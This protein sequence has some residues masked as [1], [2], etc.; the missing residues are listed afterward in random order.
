MS[1]IQ[2]QLNAALLA[3]A[4]YLNIN[5]GPTQ[6]LSQQAL[7]DALTSANAS[8][9]LTTTEIQMISSQYDLVATQMA[10]VTGFQAMVFQKHGASGQPGDYVISFRGTEFQFSL[11][12]AADL[13]SDLA[14]V[15]AGQAG[16]QDAALHTFVSNLTKPI[17]QGGYGFAFGPGS[18]DATGHSLGG[19]LVQALMSWQ[20]SLIHQGYTFNGAGMGGSPLNS[21]AEAVHA[22]R[23]AWLQTKGFS[24]NILNV[25]GDAG[26]EVVPSL[27]GPKAGPVETMFIESQVLPTDNHSLALQVDSL[28]VYRAFEALTGTSQFKVDTVTDILRA[29]TASPLASLET[30]VDWFAAMFPS[31]GASSAVP[32]GDRNALHLAASNLTSYLTG[33][34][35]GSYTL[36][37]LQGISSTLAS[38]AAQNDAQGLALRYA[39][40]NAIP[41]IVGGVDYAA[42]FNQGHR[43]D[44]ANFSSDY[45]S[46]R[47]Q[48]LQALF[49][50]NTKDLT[51]STTIE[52]GLVYRD[53]ASA[54]TLGNV[55]LPDVNSSRQ[56]VFG[57]DLIGDTI[58][59]G[60]QAD[61]LYGEGGN[62]TL[63]GA[64]GND[65]L[66]GGAGNDIL[67]GGGGVTAAAGGVGN[68]TYKYYT[69]DGLLNISDT[70]G[71]NNISVNL[72][73]SS[74]VLGTDTVSQMSAGSNVWQDTHGNRFT[75]NSD[76]VLS[77]AL[78]DGGQITIKSF[79]SGNFG[80]NL[81][82]P[83]TVT[84]PG[85]SQSFNVGAPNQV[86]ANQN[87]TT[88]Q[89]NGWY[90]SSG[91]D[92]GSWLSAGALFHTNATEIISATAAI[93][94]PANNQYAYAAV[95]AGMGDSYITG[96]SGTNVMYDDWVAHFDD[97]VPGIYGE[98]QMAAQMGND[99]IDAGG[100]N[101]IVVTRG[102][103]DVVDGGAGD[104]I[105]IDTHSGYEARFATNT[106]YLYSWS[107][108]EWV[109]Q[110]GHTS[111]DQM[112]GGVGNDFMAAHGG[113][114]TMDGGA[115][116]DEL[117]AGAGNDQ[118]SGGADNDVLGGDLYLS[119]TPL[120]GTYDGLGNLM[121][122]ALDPNAA[123]A[124]D[125]VSYGNDILD[126]GTGNDTLFGGG[127][128]DIL[129]GGDGADR[130]Q[131]D[132][133]FG[134]TDL[135]TSLQNLAADP[136]AI[137]G[138]DRLYGGAGDDQM[139]GGGGND[140][141]DGG[142]ENDTMNG[143]DGTDVMY[144]GAGN[145][146]M[147]ADYTNLSQGDDELHGGDGIDT[148]YG[149]GGN[150]FL[151]GD[152][153][154]DVI[155]GG[156]GGTISGSGDD[157]LDGGDGN[158]QLY[159]QDGNDTLTGGA[160]S[161]TVYGGS[162]DDRLTA[163][164]GYD[165][166]FGDDGNDTFVL[167]TGIGGVSISDTYGV[168]KLEFTGG[169]TAADLRLVTS[170][171][172]LFLWYSATD[173]VVLS[174]ATLDDI[175]SI[176]FSQDQPVA[177]TDQILDQIYKPAVLTNDPQNNP[178]YNQINLGTG[179]RASDIGYVAIN[180]DL[181]LTYS[182]AV[183][184]WVDTTDLTN[185]GALVS[186]K[187]GTDYG[188]APGTQVLVLHNWYNSPRID[189]LGI[190]HDDVGTNT[191]FAATAVALPHTYTGTPGADDYEGTA[192]ADKLTGGAGD[193]L[194]YGDAGNDTLAGG[195][196]T[197]ALLGGTGDDVYQFNVGDGADV[198]L[199]ESGN[200]TLSF[201][202]GITPGM[203]TVTQDGQDVLFTV[204]AAGD[205]V[206]VSNWT[207][208]DSYVVDHV[209]F[210]NGTSWNVI[211]VEQQLPGNHRPHN[212]VPMADQ[213]ATRGQAF[214]YALPAGT[215]AD[216][217]AGDTLTYTATLAD[218][219]A[220]PAW[221]LFN[222]TTKSF[223]GI[224]G[225]NDGGTVQVKVTAT[226]PSGLSGL[227]TFSLRVPAPVTLT[228]TSAA[229]TL[230]ATTVDDYTLY[231]LAGDD[232]LTG[233][234]GSDWL[235]GGAGSD[236]LSGGGGSDVYFY[237]L[238]DGGD[239]I[240]GTQDTSPTSVDM[241]Q[242]GS[243]IRPQ[244]VVVNFGGGAAPSTGMSLSIVDS[245]TGAV[246]QAFSILSGFDP[247]IGQNI[248]DGVRF[249]D[250]TT[251][252]RAD[253]LAKY[254][255]GG[256]GADII[257][258][259][260]T[261]DLINGNAG[262]DYLDG[263]AGN[264]DL[265]GGAG[266]DQIIGGTGDDTFHFGHGQ[267]YDEIA[268]TSGVN[269]IVLDAG[270]TPAD[271]TFYRTSSTGPVAPNA[272]MPAIASDGLVLVLNG[273][274]EQMWVNNFFGG[275]SP[276]P[277]NQIVFA[278]GTI[279]D[280]AAIDA[281]TVNQG[282]TA[283][284][285][286]G[287]AGNDVFT[288]DHRSDVINEAANAGTDQVNSSV[289]Y[290]LAA[291]LENLT[292][293]GVLNISGIGNA[294]QNNI[295]GN[296]G[297][298]YLYGG[299]IPGG[300]GTPDGVDTLTGGAGNDTY[301]VDKGASSNFF[302]DV[303]VEAANG[304][305][306][307][308]IVHSYSA[309]IPTNV[310]K[311]IVYNTQFTGTYSVVA[312]QVT[313][314]ALNNY[315]D[316]TLHSTYGNG[317][318]ID[319]GAGADTMIGPTRTSF[320]GSSPDRTVRYIVDN[321]GDIAIGSA[322]ITDVVVSSVSYTIGVG[323]DTLEL[324]G[325]AAISGTGNA[326]DNTMNG[327]LNTA[328]NA[329]SGGAGNDTYIVGAGDTVTENASEGTDTVQV[330]T[331]YTLGANIENLTLTGTGF[332]D[333]TGNS[334]DNVIVA[335]TANNGITGGGG[336]DTL[337]GG[338]GADTY[339]FSAG[340]GTDTIQDT[341]TGSTQDASVDTIVF[342]GTVSHFGVDLQASS[343][344][345]LDLLITE[346]GSSDTITVKNYFATGTAQDRIEQIAFVD[347]TTWTATAIAAQ[348][349]A[350]RGTAGSDTL[351]AASGGSVM[352]GLAGNDTLNGGA[353]DDTLDGG[354]GVDTLNGGAGNDAYVVDNTADVVNE[355]AA[356]GTDTV[357]AVANYTLSNNVENLTLIGAGAIN[358]TGNVLNNS[359]VGNAA[360]NTLSGGAG[361]DYLIG[362]AGN[363][364]L[365][366]GAGNDQ[367]YGDAGTDVMTGG[368]G[369]DTYYVDS[370]ADTVVE[371]AGLV[372]DSDSVNT[373]LD[374]YV[375][376]AN[377][378][379][380]LIDGNSGA[381]TG[382][383]NAADNYI[384]ASG[385]AQ[386]NVLYGLAGNDTL[387]GVDGMDTLVGGTGNDNYVI[388]NTDGFIDTIVENVG[389]GY[390]WA[391]IQSTLGVTYVLSANVDAAISYGVG[392]NL[393]GNALD[394]ELDGDDGDNIL[395][396]GTG[397]DAL[398][399]HLGN[400]TFV[401]DNAG[402]TVFENAGEGTDT[403]QSSISY[404]LGANLEKLTLTGSANINATGNAVANTVT[405]NSGNNV[406]DGGA[407]ADAMTGGA[408][409]DT[410]VV[411]VAGD[412]ITEG[413]SAGTDTV[414]SAITYT[415]GSNVENLTLTGSAAINGTGNTLDNVLTGNSGNNTLTGNAGNDTLDG[416]SAGTDSL[417]GGA[418][419]DIYVVNRST[420]I[421]LTEAASAGTDTVQASVTYTLATNFENLTLTGTSAIN[422]TGNTVA[423][424]ITGNSGANTLDGGTGADTLI[425]GAGNDIYTV[426]NTGDIVTENASE[427]TDQVNASVT[428]TIGNNIEN[429]TLTGSTAI[430]GTGNTLDNA[431]TGNS[432]NNTLTGLAGNDTLDAG[433][434][435]TDVMV[436]GLGNDT[437]VVG[438]A[439]GITITENAG[440]GTDLVNASVTYT[441][442]TNVE[443]LTL[444]GSTAINGTGNTLDNVLTGNSG[445][446]TLTGL[447]GNDTLDGGTAGTD[448]MVGGTGNDTYIVNRTT[449]LTLTENAN[450][451]IDSVSASVTQT[452]GANIE[453][454]FLTG[455][456]ATNGTGNTLANL[457]R[458]NTGVNTLVGGGGADILEG[459]GGNDILSNTS[460]NTLLDGGAG[461]D[462]M[463][464]AANNDLL[465]GGTGND[466]LT[467]GQ[468]ADIIAF[469]KGDGVD[470]VAA[471]TTTDNTLSIG[472]G[473]L[474]A[475]LVFQ[476]SGTDLILKV[477]ATDQITFTGYYTGSNRSVNNLQVVIEGTSDY[478]SGSTNVIN[479]KKVETFNFGGLVAAFDAAL[480]A[481]P[482]LT[483][484]SLTNA[485]A[486]QYL[487]GS[488]TAALGGD[489]AYQ[490]AR[491]GNLSNVSFTPAEALL[492]AAGF[493]TTA[494]ALQALASLQDAT[495][496][497]S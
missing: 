204:G 310:E 461:N 447:A 109:N 82:A 166:L 193:D 391:D 356:S 450:E 117:Y 44:A 323:I 70:Q 300:G 389:E 55:A 85:G 182:G 154:D 91:A 266:N 372:G 287:T 90:R 94:N 87:Q 475:D 477:G 75:L 413:A 459:G 383:G 296:S 284:T 29:S 43:Y 203:V 445:N 262:D 318:T 149:M 68:D 488:D 160:G 260:S 66:D 431:L 338:A 371:G 67:I 409:N 349:N 441:L 381:I 22:L 206:R 292:L 12:T 315:I 439:T 233:N 321:V 163:D 497:L 159:G 394:N 224:P 258:G 425:G 343:S 299:F 49:D 264:D 339:Y 89:A 478:N 331:S 162:G 464:G 496:R 122:I 146:Q 436:G 281:H 135:R 468:G 484:W 481:N 97:A 110:A 171:S 38:S 337:K 225:N 31:S 184:S 261:N 11:G 422:G 8:G 453:A 489:L 93:S 440:E 272:Y 141:M 164:S 208:D 364:T 221:L 282:G 473:A 124:D 172:S 14:L 222:P 307:T 223:S 27:S 435:G 199:E 103:D 185:R 167:G 268:D 449:G 373:G 326:L 352:K 311:M 180:N 198:I 423:N 336:N 213:T 460:G 368:D 219:S 111:N 176:T 414:Q 99:H 79:V 420:G 194:L 265:T 59:G 237:N 131:G 201:G 86:V 140:Y 252:T 479:N 98:Y 108:T 119:A 472:G 411:D 9:R 188:L 324:S 155:A 60:A 152:A 217:N 438:R 351:T 443:N 126:G 190:L 415:L 288:V 286:T 421:T 76:G 448:V 62:D 240:L 378:E 369:S 100:G 277:I 301:E 416:G 212:V 34:G 254:L 218:G 186:L 150:D 73:G 63:N 96:D 134:Y 418:G 419:N 305:Y 120:L 469:N 417:V 84:P 54:T 191:T 105:L 327:S 355:A 470:T 2:D 410:Y 332:A 308:L 309:V 401:I 358:G 452:L 466:A 276:R 136:T 384:S 370:L 39:M 20:P 250:G 334:L 118:L 220:L 280:A 313:G 71:V 363:D 232:T 19:H 257:T 77:I 403:V 482:S 4:A 302:D 340:A 442:G 46:D 133:L 137:Q 132:T 209:N 195:T 316:A 78:Q 335:N 273:T 380:L 405:G 388:D 382:T 390:D 130:M 412:T 456:T 490:Y 322:N 495:P 283:N 161:D 246:T 178:G 48:Y 312:Q 493:G 35:A 319:G 21:A 269:R 121:S 238:G 196:G 377:F 88:E 47:A 101:D 230:T 433:T 148:M 216:A 357:Y 320:T 81:G 295:L 386:D 151:Y 95:K 28:M 397:A 458:G 427:G 123:L 58:T 169:V 444:T 385:S 113:K 341:A 24:T 214:S 347:G 245:T 255:T 487:S 205:T 104:D 145:D 53:L 15:L 187:P 147:V 56:I 379:N 267:G 200:D 179:V 51:F 25:I 348:I 483:S 143:G 474:Y 170:G 116:N 50:A 74:Y 189:Y 275:Q 467:T 400:D 457:L 360:A 42:L 387:D 247:S 115:N 175:G 192:G 485:L 328:A 228:G 333:G 293:T 127:G 424:V 227:G 10:G 465:I 16:L 52:P 494:Q 6:Q 366:G 491:N 402:D 396:G 430:N 428:Y 463:T 144:G 236:F 72:S 249:S 181:L 202:A 342:D 64:G 139:W 244:D 259:F 271:V 125:T 23:L 17:G 243:G 362:G 5:V 18:L 345:P 367:L 306:D 399:G 446:N 157:H 45:L 476:K 177:S 248:I 350:I 353:G 406:L 437:Y 434:A 65:T 426:D 263:G 242:F 486:T 359:I 480:V 395:D 354:S 462:T 408:G 253:L 153:G 41:F 270:I 392:N 289:S 393:T 183:S 407:G 112:S 290:T 455:S 102:G 142:S 69:G 279:W 454:L 129:Y 314:N 361:D 207:S 30:V 329:L 231:G 404:A 229:D 36:V 114:Q 492:G 398:Y 40:L 32:L 128:D 211:Q 156:A 106:S 291:N 432:G 210:Q 304:G 365:D 344:N 376:G 107:S 215:F 1:T 173:Y 174:R 92:G 330:G 7:T 61:R 346:A 375:L 158:D 239:T 80:I 274:G 165:S 234:A 471:S 317:Y 325:S 33:P 297:D 197:D 429:L 37:G 226:D 3:D 294:L 298:N 251:W 83:Q 138:N 303:I 26:L 285:Q 57:D 256:A 13:A 278:D 374:N 168:N 241:V 451:G 235:E